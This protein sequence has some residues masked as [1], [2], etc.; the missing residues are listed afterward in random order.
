MEVTRIDQAKPYEAPRH[1][2][3]TALR[4]QGWDATSATFAWV[5]LSTIKPGGGAEMEAG[6]LAKIYVVLEGTVTVV[7]GDGSVTELGA[8]DSC[9]I[10]VGEARSVEW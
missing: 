1:N 6:G 10:P 3:V 2:D 5:G 4:L 7:L 8:H 9:H